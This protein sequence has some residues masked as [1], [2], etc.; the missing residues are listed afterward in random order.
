ML[1]VL[2]VDAER[3]IGFDLN[4]LTGVEPISHDDGLHL[5]YQACPPHRAHTTH[6][7]RPFH[8]ARRIH[9][10]RRFYRAHAPHQPTHAHRARPVHH[11]RRRPTDGRRP[12]TEFT[13]ANAALH[14]V[15]RNNEDEVDIADLDLGMLISK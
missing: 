6:R 11:L 9:R 2:I 5:P 10:V 8:Q 15:K 7:T 4:D 12:R 13:A 3:N 1:S 14:E